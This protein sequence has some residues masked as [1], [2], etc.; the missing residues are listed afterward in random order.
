MKENASIEIRYVEDKN[1][2]VGTLLVKST[3][4]KLS[5]EN[6]EEFK[7]WTRDRFKVNFPEGLIDVKVINT[8]YD[9]KNE[10]KYVFF[11]TKA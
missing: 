1:D 2:R 6:G 9:N 8:V 5:A 7:M 10:D 4:D 3:K 11:V